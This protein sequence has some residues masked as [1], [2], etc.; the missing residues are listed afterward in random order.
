[1]ELGNDG[2]NLLDGMINTLVNISK[3]DN[4]DRWQKLKSE[5]EKKNKINGQGYSVY[6][7][8][9]Q[10]GIIQEIFKI[11]GTTNKT[12]LEFGCGDGTQNNS[13]YLLTCKKD[14]KGLWIDG[15]P[16]C[17]RKIEDIIPFL[18]NSHRLTVSHSM[19]ERQNI[20]D[21]LK[22]YCRDSD[23]DLMIMD[24]DWNDLYIWE[25]INSIK[26]RVVCLE[27]NSHIPPDT[28]LCVPYSENHNPWNG[29]NYFGASLL[30]FAELAKEKGYTLVACSLAGSDAF[31]VRNDLM[32]DA[33]KYKTGITWHASD[34][35]INSTVEFLFEP[36]RYN[37]AFSMGHPHHPWANA[38]FVE[39]SKKQMEEKNKGPSI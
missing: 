6:S 31:F 10:D 7:M 35:D 21:L 33:F 38:A 20:D 5:S 17:I 14:W 4:Y 34:D 39:Y 27:Y 37:L 26:P 36:A 19:I 25:A 1:M 29:G 22:S 13:L 28:S 12:F 24:L 30:A 3:A 16:E 23:P 18:V 9:D 2:L 32:N 8:H 11:I 15:D